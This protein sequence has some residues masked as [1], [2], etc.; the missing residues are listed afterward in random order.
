MIGFAIGNFVIAVVWI[1]LQESLKMSGWKRRVAD[2]FSFF[3]VVN[4]VIQE[5][6]KIRTLIYVKYAF[7][8]DRATVRSKNQAG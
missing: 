8:L 2:A 3:E 4:H 6:A 7:T 1:N 5:A